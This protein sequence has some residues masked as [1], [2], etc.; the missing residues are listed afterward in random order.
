M[1]NS[2]RLLQYNSK[3]DLSSVSTR[4]DLLSATDTKSCS[5]QRFPKQSEKTLDAPNF[6]DDYYLNNLDWSNWG[7]LAIALKD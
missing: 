1:L 7:P 3:D 4:A 6:V 2:S 5:K